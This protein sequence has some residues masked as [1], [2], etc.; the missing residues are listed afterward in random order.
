MTKWLV[1]VLLLVAVLVVLGLLFAQMP[2]VLVSAGETAVFRAAHG[3]PVVC[4]GTST[5]LNLLKSVMGQEFRTWNMC[6][7]LSNTNHGWNKLQLREA[8][9]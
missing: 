5:G 4:R 8:A 2:M 3:D 7:H 1:A 6:G 9:P